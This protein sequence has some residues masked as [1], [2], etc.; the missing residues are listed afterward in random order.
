MK[1]MR[2]LQTFSSLVA[3]SAGVTRVVC[4]QP[5]GLPLPIPTPMMAPNPRSAGL[6]PAARHLPSY[7]HFAGP[8]LRPL[9]F[10]M[11]L[12]P[13]SDPGRQDIRKPSRARQG[14]VEARDGEDLSDPEVIRGLDRS[15]LAAAR[16][17]SLGGARPAAF[18]V[19][20]FP[21]LQPQFPARLQAPRPVR[22]LS[23][24]D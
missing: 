14:A 2:N 20:I 18:D 12:V 21:S 19:S 4:A 11:P 1:R 16:L 24:S 9:T 6:G 23:G 13:V 7:P 17:H 3:R 5:C 15:L 10:A 22:P 8:D